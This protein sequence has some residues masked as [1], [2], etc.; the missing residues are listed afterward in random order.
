MIFRCDL[1]GLREGVTSKAEEEFFLLLDIRA[2][3]ETSVS[4]RVNTRQTL[5]V[6]YALLTTDF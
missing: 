5:V 4:S 1:L 3:L 6:S 2:K